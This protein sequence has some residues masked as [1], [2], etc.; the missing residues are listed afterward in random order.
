MEN[1]I[2]CVRL[3]LLFFR[4]VASL[5]HL[6]TESVVP[7][8]ILNQ[9]AHFQMFDTYPV[10]LQTLLNHTKEFPLHIDGALADSIAEPRATNSVPS[11]WNSETQNLPDDNLSYEKGLLGNHR[12]AANYLFALQISATSNWAN[13]VARIR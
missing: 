7:S 2:F 13:P 3:A 9:A 1:P 8:A 10:S 11:A 6:L 5:I 4:C 12:P